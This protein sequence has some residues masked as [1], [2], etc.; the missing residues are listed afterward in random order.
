MDDAATRFWFSNLP[1]DDVRLCLHFLKLHKGKQGASKIF[2][3]L[4]RK[5]PHARLMRSLMRGFL[6][7]P[8]EPLKEKIGI[9]SIQL[10]H[11]KKSLKGRFIEDDPEEK[12]TDRPRS[13]A[14]TKAS[15]DR[16]WDTW[17]ESQQA[18][19]EKGPAQRASN[20]TYQAWEKRE[21]SIKPKKS[22]RKKDNTNGGN[23]F[24]FDAPEST[25]E[26]RYHHEDGNTEA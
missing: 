9:L 17:Y 21:P 10:A 23:T 26:N 7:V 1:D 8:S 3:D 15:E 25:E 11:L 2:T 18:R 5:K 14:D 12:R 19:R 16:A 20:P 22:R 24:N 6:D 4:I 13:E